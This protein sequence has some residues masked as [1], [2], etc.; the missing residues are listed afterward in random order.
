MALR[1]VALDDYQGLVV[2]YSLDGRPGG[3]EWVAVREHLAGDDL[4]AALGGA[5]VIVAMRERTRFD[6]EL[7]SRLP[8]LELLI[9]TGRANAS[10][11]VRAAADHGVTVCSTGGPASANTAELA[12]GLILS[13]QRHLPAEIGAVRDGHWQHTVGTDLLG[14]TMGLVGMGRIGHQMARIAHAFEMEVIAWSQHLDPAVAAEAGVRAVSKEDLF[15]A[16]DVVSIHLV[17]SERTRHL[18]TERELR[19]MKPSAVIVNTSRGPIIDSA[20]L[21]RAL[22]EGWI[23]GAGLDV[24]DTE[25]LP[26]D[27]PLR[28]APRTV[29]TPHIGYVT[30][31]TMAHWYEDA[32]ENIAA[33]QRGEPIRVL[34]AS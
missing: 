1:V 34:T 3:A 16:A 29:L 26:A 7:F 31:R 15:A 32:V 19:S 30:A 2:E 28:S 6:R 24:Y 11:D 20:A 25:P 14:A 22:R 4:V 17:L 8:H 23:A 10:I 13:L 5:T 27:D 21:L 33:W 12:W 9:T 18:V